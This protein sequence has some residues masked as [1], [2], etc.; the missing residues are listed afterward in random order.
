MTPEVGQIAPDFTLTAHTGEAISLSQY[1][2]QQ[3]V[4]LFFVRA[5]SCWHCREHVEQLGR[6]YEQFKAQQTEVLVV[7]DASPEETAEYAKKVHAPFPVLANPGHTVYEMYGLNKVFFF[8]SRSGSLVVDQQGQIS[9]LKSAL[10]TTAWLKESLEVL[11]HVK[12]LGK[13]A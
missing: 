2:G 12:G 13:A 11:E 3:N 4:I 1:R 10:I 9:Y 5:P 6:L 8:T 7:I